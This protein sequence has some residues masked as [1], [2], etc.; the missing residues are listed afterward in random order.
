MHNQLVFNGK[1]LLD[2]GV[3]LTNS[4]VYT[5]PN[6]SVE[7]V[8]VP[9]RDGSLVLDNG[10]FENIEIE[11]PCV[12]SDGFMTKFIE[13]SSFLSSQI[14]YCR[15][16]DN[17]YP[18]HFRIGRFVSVSNKSVNPK[19]DIGTFVLKFNCKPQRFLKSG[20]EVI[21]IEQSGMIRNSTLHDAKPKIR[22]YGKGSLVVGSRTL[23]IDNLYPNS[24]IDIDCDAMNASYGSTNFNNYVSGE[25]PVLE[26]GDNIITWGGSSAEIIPRWWTL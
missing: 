1:S 16:E 25:F 14:G 20:E 5:I 12:I 26:P 2:F 24:Y 13:M 3:Y 21:E 17:F 10:S 22:L 4:G 9:G 6:R 8:N 18:E 15:I 19:G 23:T 11:Y 7:S